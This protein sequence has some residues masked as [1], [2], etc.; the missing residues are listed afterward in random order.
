M[1][2][3]PVISTEGRNLYSKVRRPDELTPVALDPESCRA[4]QEVAYFTYN[5]VYLQSDAARL[6]GP[7]PHAPSLPET[8]NKY[9]IPGD[10]SGSRC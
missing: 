2:V 10:P 3:S 4:S 5:G 6:A 1:L 7:L 8:K 9:I